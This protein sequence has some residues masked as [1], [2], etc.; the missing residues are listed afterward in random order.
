M[1]IILGVIF[2]FGLIKDIFNHNQS[3]NSPLTKIT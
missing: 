3:S 1:L 2:L